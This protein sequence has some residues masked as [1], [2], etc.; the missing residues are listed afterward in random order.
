[1]ERITLERQGPVAWLRMNRPE[2]LNGFDRPMIDAMLAR[3]AEL[4]R[5]PGVRGVVLTGEGR[6]FCTGLDTKLLAAGGIDTGYFEGWED[7]FEA[8]DGLEVPLVA[9]V[10]GHCLGG[11][12]SL[13]LCADYR[14][15]ADDLV[16]GLGAVRLGVVPGYLYRLAEA[17][18]T[19]AAR[20]LTLFAEYLGPE[21]AL[22]IGL[23]DAV[24]PVDRLEEAARE[25]AARVCEFPAEGVRQAKRLLR[26]ASPLDAAAGRARQG[27][28]EKR[29][30]AALDAGAPARSTASGA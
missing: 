16:I 6:A 12:M 5:D 1:M 19:M 4:R 30:L 21:E 23:V 14:I 10:R 26:Q 18:G 15:A 9:A 24:V 22:R 20:R 3:L 2:T 11:G 8:L 17:V 27:A 7:I 29:C 25:A 13:L 28:A